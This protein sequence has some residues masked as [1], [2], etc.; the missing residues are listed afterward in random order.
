[1]ELGSGCVW[2]SVGL[3][4]GGWMEASQHGRAVHTGTMWSEYAEGL[5]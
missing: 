1:M 3:E 2:T 5:A 4:R